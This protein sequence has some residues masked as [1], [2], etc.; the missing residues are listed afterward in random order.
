MQQS[1]GKQW[2]RLCPF[3]NIILLNELWNG[4]ER[5]HKSLH[6][7]FPW[8]SPVY[9]L[10]GRS[11]VPL[12]V[13]ICLTALHKDLPIASDIFF[14][15]HLGCLFLI[16]IFEASSFEFIWSLGLSKP[17]A[18]ILFP[19]FL[20]IKS[21]WIPQWA[22]NFYNSGF[23]RLSHFLE[24]YHLFYFLQGKNFLILYDLDNPLRVPKESPT[25]TL[26]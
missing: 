18:S 3:I 13:I 10:G 24:W 4:R 8:Y 12:K 16:N 20:S 6:N 1:Q 2:S 9:Q 17:N 11:T 19:Y 22:M 23:H 25:L 14:S 7:D 26:V 15:Y 5:C 21:K